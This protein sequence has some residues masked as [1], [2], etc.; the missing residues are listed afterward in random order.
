MHQTL[1]SKHHAVLEINSEALKNN[2]TYLKSLLAPNTK[3]MAMVKANAYG[4][5]A[6]KIAKIL[7]QLNVD[8]L[9]VAYPV[10]AI[11]LRKKGIKTPI[12]VMNTDQDCYSQLIGHHAEPTIF[13]LEILEIFGNKIKKSP[14][15]LSYPIHLEINTGM[16]RVGFSPK[17]SSQVLALLKKFPQLEVKS[18]FSHFAESDNLNN[19]EFTEQQIAVFKE[20]SQILTNGLGYRPLLHISNSSGTTNFPE[21]HLDMVRI[22]I[23]LYGYSNHPL[24]QENLQHVASLKTYISQIHDIQKGESVSY[25]RNFIAKKNI[26]IATLSIGYADGIPRNLSNGNYAVAINGKLAPIT[27]IICMDMLMVD[28]SHIDCQVGDEVTFFGKTPTFIE[29]AEKAH[30]IPYEILTSISP[31]VKRKFF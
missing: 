7:N 21:A 1:R 17:E 20:T 25:S 13:S 9:G 30:T 5:G 10:E 12:M 31:R 4:L 16:N 8:Y 28:I 18:I 6:V 24:H 19:T 3:I 11:K 2:Y 29:M 22:G 27:G 15:H 23:G 26:K 14:F